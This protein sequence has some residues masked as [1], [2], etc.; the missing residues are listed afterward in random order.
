MANSN[1]NSLSTFCDI[2]S[3]PSNAPSSGKFVP[4]SRSGVASCPIA[5]AFLALAFALALVRAQEDHQVR[6][7]SVLATRSVLI[8]CA[9]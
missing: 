3:T 5:S 7:L 4:C 2:F 8:N 1:W 6:Q 9:S